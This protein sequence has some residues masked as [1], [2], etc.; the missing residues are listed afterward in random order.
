MSMATLEEWARMHTDAI[1]PADRKKCDQCQEMIKTFGPMPAREKLWRFMES[2]TNP[3]PRPKKA[4]ISRRLRNEI[5]ARDNYTCR[6]CGSDDELTVDHIY[7]ESKGGTRE[8]ENLQT[9][10]RS[11]NSRKGARVE[12]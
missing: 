11:C 6:Y 8:P 4:I 9:L 2:Q 7:P 1:H 3:K 5:F 12:E 10:C